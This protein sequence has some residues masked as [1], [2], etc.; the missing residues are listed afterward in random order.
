MTTTTNN[1]IDL[2]EF[3]DDPDCTHRYG[4][5]TQKR[6]HIIKTLCARCGKEIGRVEDTIW[7]EKAHLNFTPQ[8][9]EELK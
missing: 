4:L 8:E 3:F 7:P 6:P 9:V 2:P 5:L 1:N